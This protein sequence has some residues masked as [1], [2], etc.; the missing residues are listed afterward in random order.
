MD[1]LS[2]IEW[3]IKSKPTTCIRKSTGKNLTKEELNLIAIEKTKNNK[4]ICISFPVNDNFKYYVT[5]EYNESISVEKLLLIIYYFYKEPMDLSKLD[6]IFYEMDEWKDE[7]I[8]YYD[9]NLNKLTNYDA[10]TDTCTP[11]FCGLEYDKKTK[12]YNV[13]IGPE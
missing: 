2:D 1:L 7:V 5:R 6:D 3:Y 9:G 11:D 10:F 4:N 13:I 12:S 8:N